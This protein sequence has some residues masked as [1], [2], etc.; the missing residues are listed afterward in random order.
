MDDGAT[1]VD[2]KHPAGTLSITANGTYN[3]ADYASANVSVPFRYNM[4]C[5]LAKA[6]N[7]YVTELTVNNGDIY[8]MNA[9]YPSNLRGCSVIVSALQD[10]GQWC[11]VKAT[12][13]KIYYSGTGGIN[14]AYRIYATAG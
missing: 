10:S 1:W 4:N 8:V 5:V 3:V 11:I 14:M 13:T 7:T 6:W 9:S 12:S 2:F